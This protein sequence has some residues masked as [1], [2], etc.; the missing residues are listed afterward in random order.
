MIRAS[1]HKCRPPMTLAVATVFA[2]SLSALVLG[3]RPPEGPTIPLYPNAQ[4]TRLPRDQIAEVAGPIERIDG[5]QVAG[6]RGYFDL[7]PGCHVVELEHRLSFFVVGRPA[8]GN[9]SYLL[10]LGPLPTVTYALR[11]K[12][13]ARYVIRQEPHLGGFWTINGI[14]RSAREEQPNG[15]AIELAPTESADEIRACKEWEATTLRGGA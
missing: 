6:W 5:N 11:M 9:G 14:Y 3:C 8:R 15:P 2:V 12:A 7:L 4:T 13:G 10:Q 1:S